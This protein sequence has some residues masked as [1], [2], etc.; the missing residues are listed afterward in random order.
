MFSCM[1]QQNT[2]RTQYGINKYPL[3]S[4]SLCLSKKHNIVKLN[5]II[6][7]PKNLKHK[8]GGTSSTLLYA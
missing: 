1:L 4:L 5:S 3:R 7:F 2:K 8:Q 6:K